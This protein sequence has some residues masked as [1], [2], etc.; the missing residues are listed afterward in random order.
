MP[1][2]R[3][4]LPS[5][6]LLCLSYRF[7]PET[8]PLALGLRDVLQEWKKRW[9][10]DVVTAADEAASE[11]NVTVHHVKER[12]PE[13]F[14]R[15]LRRLRLGRLKELLVWPDPFVFWVLPAFLRARQVIKERRPE[16]IF[17]FM[18]PFSTGFAGALLKKVTGLP[19]ILN[20][21]D[22]PTCSDMHSSFPSRLHYRA[23]RWMEDLFVRFSDAVV[24]VSKRNMERVRARQPAGQ[25]HKF[26]LVR[27]GASLKGS[28]ASRNGTLTSSSRGKRRTGTEDPFE[29]TY[30]GAMSG[31]YQLLQDIEEQPLHKRLFRK[32]KQ[33]GRFRSAALDARTHSPVFIGLA[34]RRVLERHPE[35]Q[36]KLE[37]HI[38]GDRSPKEVVNRVLRHFALE[39]V[40]HVHRPVSHEAVVRL[41]READLLFMTLPDRADGTAG[42][43]ISAKTYEYLSTD[44]PIL[45][46]LPLGENRD[47]L[48]DKAG[49]HLAMPKDVAGMADTIEELASEKFAGQPAD[50][51]R[52]GLQA[53]L[54]G[55]TR[56][57]ALENVIADATRSC[58]DG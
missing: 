45:A 52:S 18:M 31:W 6:K 56:A 41:Q 3:K 21:D 19:L 28:L 50:I 25:Q 38:Y 34:V 49:T 30:T 40:V 13:R 47:Y 1:R 22:S 29:I 32:W 7:P 16:A 20:L 12:T 9:T 26:H 57:K 37:V 53:A 58:T 33:L 24:Y 36:G 55:K 46:A 17:V 35:W 5:G 27:Y 10:I 23:S 8:Y 54:T 48:K 51:D 11:G 14:L 42:G 15:L 4:E 39:E 43:R 44:R 2:S